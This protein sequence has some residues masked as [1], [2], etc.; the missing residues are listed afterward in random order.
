MIRIN[1]PG[2]LFASYLT[3]QPC[4]NPVEGPTNVWWRRPSNRTGE[5][6]SA[7]SNPPYQYTILTSSFT[8][9]SRA[10]SRCRKRILDV[11]PHWSTFTCAAYHHFQQNAPLFLYK[12]FFLLLPYCRTAHQSHKPLDTVKRPEMCIFTTFLNFYAGYCYNMDR[13]CSSV[14]FISFYTIIHP[15]F[16]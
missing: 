2:H 3:P 6:Q 8:V 11:V 15:V 14:Y 4:Q 13:S 12:P 7:V 10:S 9:H 5:A 1:S 16:T